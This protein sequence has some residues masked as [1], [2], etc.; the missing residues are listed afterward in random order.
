MTQGLIC[1]D[2]DDSIC[3]SSKVDARQIR[4]K[5]NLNLQERQEQTQQAIPITVLPRS[6][7]VFPQPQDPNVK[8][9]FYPS[10][11]I[12]FFSGFTPPHPHPPPLS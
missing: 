7:P 3:Y 12:A 6:P 4:L 8:F 5:E 1:M 2:I 10:T 9:P 11:P